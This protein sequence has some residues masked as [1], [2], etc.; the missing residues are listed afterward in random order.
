MECIELWIRVGAL[1][2]ICFGGT[3]HYYYA[4]SQMKAADCYL[5]TLGDRLHTL[6]ALHSCHSTRSSEKI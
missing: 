1:A 5:Y 2:R 4:L 6:H 3:R